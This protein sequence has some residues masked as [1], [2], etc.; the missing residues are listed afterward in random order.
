MDAHQNG[1]IPAINQWRMLAEQS[2]VRERALRDAVLPLHGFGPNSEWGKWVESG[3][4]VLPGARHEFVY[5][6]VPLSAKEGDNK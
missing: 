5:R 1:C 4:V 2:E 6:F 3:V